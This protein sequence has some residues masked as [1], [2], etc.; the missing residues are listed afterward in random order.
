MVDWNK[1]RK[2]AEQ[3]RN[4]GQ[5]GQTSTVPSWDKARYRAAAEGQINPATG[6]FERTPQ[7]L[8]T[9]H[10]TPIETS[11]PYQQ[12][13]QTTAI[14]L[15]PDPNTYDRYYSSA[16][17]SLFE[18]AKRRITQEDVG[19]K[20]PAEFERL[21]GTLGGGVAS[22]LGTKALLE[23]VGK[24]LQRVPYKPVQAVGKALPH[25]GGYFASGA[26][27]YYGAGLPENMTAAYEKWGIV[28]K[29]TRD[30]TLLDNEQL[31]NVM[32]GELI[33]DMGLGAAGSAVKHT[34]RTVSRL[35]GGASKSTEELAVAAK[36][37]GMPLPQGAFE[38][39]LL[40]RL[41]TPVFARFPLWGG[42]LIRAGNLVGQQMVDVLNMK[43]MGPIVAET[44]V[45][46]RM[47]DASQETMKAFNKRWQP[48]YEA[49]WKRADDLQVKINPEIVRQSAE[50][51]L[52]Q[53]ARGTVRADKL[54]PSEK[55]LHKFIT[56]KILHPDSAVMKGPISMTQLDGLIHDLWQT[57]TK[58]SK[59][60]GLKPHKFFGELRQGMLANAVSEPHVTSGFGSDA[61][62]AGAQQVAKDLRKLGEGFHQEIKAL[63]ETTGALKIGKYERGGLRS[64]G[65]FAPTV[66]AIDQVATT[67]AD[68]TSPQ[69]F[70]ELHK[71]IAKADPQSWQEFVE[72][73]LRKAYDASVT[74]TTKRGKEVQQFDP[75]LFRQKLGLDAPNS[76]DYEIT[77]Y[78]MGTQTRLTMKELNTFIQAAETVEHMEVPNIIQLAQRKA[79]LGGVRGAIRALMPWVG[80]AGVAGGTA[81]GVAASP[82]VAT[83]VAGAL[84]SVLPARMVSNMLAS[85]RAALPIRTIIDETASETR[86]AKAAIQ[87]F[88]LGITAAVEEGELTRED[89]NML[90]QEGRKVF[91]EFFLDRKGQPK[92]EKRDPLDLPPPLGVSPDDD[93]Q[94]AVQ[95]PPAVPDPLQ[96]RGPDFRSR[97]RPPV[98]PNA[99]FGP[100]PNQQPQ[101]SPENMAMLQ[102][103]KRV[104]TQ[105]RGFTPV[106]NR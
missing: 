20:D 42:P 22:G 78:M 62:N 91:E 8:E 33:V 40:A 82:N 71:L 103:L 53:I 1:S 11:G 77:K 60:S 24:L 5:T 10:A 80:R 31:S 47:W 96:G 17:P 90:Y 29:G 50:D 70:R 23:P 14:P 34:W 18:R 68:E 63:F 6:E 49:L 7:A 76:P 39:S 98:A 43:I 97:M 26:G 87:L 52:M 19:K 95:P 84:M 105:E 93:I 27:S 86:Q 37:L 12:Y 16:N 83:A 44:D 2:I 56:E 99:V 88:R 36:E 102:A 106:P 46:R 67:F 55:A 30:R 66:K 65:E 25:V 79:V 85:S 92:K 48:K 101:M 13:Q 75:V 100:Q 89:A 58:L 104:P 72:L 32:S 45:G 94:V 81:V 3:H 74:T 59:K 38:G 57:K 21:A 9:R 64:P 73:R 28:P 54:A 35:L 69:V 51:I 41:W 4:G 61:T 15:N